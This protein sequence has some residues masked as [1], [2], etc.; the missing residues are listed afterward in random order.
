MSASL[1]QILMY[2]DLLSKLSESIRNGTVLVDN[3]EMH[4]APVITTSGEISKAV[5]SR[6]FTLTAR[7]TTL[8]P[9]RQ[10]AEDDGVS[11]P[12]PTE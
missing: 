7:I 9:A 3:L 6:T 5:P 8:D 11:Y 10:R 1:D 4:V 2:A 12:E